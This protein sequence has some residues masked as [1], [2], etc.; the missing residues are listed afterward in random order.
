MPGVDQAVQQAAKVSYEAIMLVIIMATMLGSFGILGRW[1][2]KAQAD[3]M[4]EMVE[5]KKRMAARITALE[6]FVEQTL[7]KLVNDA[8]ILMQRNIETVS[9]LTTALNSRLCLLDI[10]KQDELVGKL[11]AKIIAEVRPKLQ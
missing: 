10:G 3:R 8:T 9:A 11:G 6:T 2:L 7:V 4:A 5:D 1:F